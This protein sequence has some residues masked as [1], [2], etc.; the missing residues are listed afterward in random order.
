MHV[1]YIKQF[2]KLDPPLNESYIQKTKLTN[3][4]HVEANRKFVVIRYYFYEFNL[5]SDDLLFRFV[6][7]L[8]KRDDH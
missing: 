1:Q 6:H 4:S 3:F 5:L 7:V 2:V 8:K